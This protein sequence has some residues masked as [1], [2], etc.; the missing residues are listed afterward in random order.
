VPGSLPDR[1]TL[2]TP[3]RQLLTAIY[4]ERC[5]GC[6]QE[7]TILCPH[8]QLG[9]PNNL[10]ACDRCALPLGDSTISRCGR[11]QAQPPPLS[12][13]WVPYLYRPPL[14]RLIAQLKFGRRLSLAR[15]LGLIWLA[16]MEQPIIRT[17]SLGLVPIPLHRQRLAERGFNQ[18]LELIRPLAAE[19]GLTIYPQLLRRSQPTPAQSR[20]TRRQRLKNL[21]G[22]FTLGDRPRQLPERLILIDD[23]ITTGTTLHEATHALAPLGVATIE[24]WALARTPLHR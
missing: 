7:G 2:L 4:P 6:G 15:S 10:H 21:R 17:E 13:V 19:L 3:W 12:R 16:A 9:W 22:A 5:V 24:A 14:D 20:L 1:A 8:C 23:V 11:C 18:A